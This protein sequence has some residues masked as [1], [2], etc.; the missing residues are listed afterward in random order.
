MRFRPLRSHVLASWLATV[1]AL[2]AAPAAALPQDPAT[3]PPRIGVFFWHDSPNDEVTFAGVKQ[4]LL[5]AKVPATF[6]VRQAN[7]DPVVA[8]QQ[9]KELQAASCNLV[10]AMGTRATQLAQ[11]HLS[12]VPIVFAA[13]TNPVTAN[14]V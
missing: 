6:L 9:L 12:G 2:A 14:I 7:S 8:A 10:L 5:A 1:A 11:Q 3:T 13:V 4:G